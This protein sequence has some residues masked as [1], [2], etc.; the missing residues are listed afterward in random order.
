[1]A[2]VS[3]TP[4]GGGLNWACSRGAGGKPAEMALEPAPPPFE[5]DPGHAGEGTDTM[6]HSKAIAALTGPLLAAM[7][8][9]MLVNRNLFPTLIGELAHNTGLIFLS[10][11]LLLLAGV[12]IVRT[13]N[14][15][16]GGWRVLVT[17]LGWLAVASGLARMWFPQAAAPIAE[18]LGGNAAGLVVAGLVLLALGAFLSYKAYGPES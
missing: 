13:H 15:W 2:G 17:V 5:P 9:A 8:V 12:A 4:S 3:L 14:V 6:A 16:S 1:M 11:L 7:G 10:G 18:T